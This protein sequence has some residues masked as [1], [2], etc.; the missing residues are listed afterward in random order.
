MDRKILFQVWKRL[1]SEKLKG[2]EVQVKVAPAEGYGDVNPELIQTINKEAFQ[3]VDKVE[4]G[5]GFGAQ[6]TDGAMQRIV[7]KK[8]DGDDITIDGNHPLAGIDLTFDV[9]MVSVREASEE[10]KTHGHSWSGWASSLK[11]Q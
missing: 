5:M 9:K 3:G 1:W 7:V 4:E 10:E 2:D 11:R 6:G 8:V